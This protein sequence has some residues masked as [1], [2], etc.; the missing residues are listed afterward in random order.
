[1]SETMTGVRVR[2]GFS[3]R[4]R[5]SPAR[6]RGRVAVAVGL[7]E[8]L[9]AAGVGAAG[10]AA[11]GDISGSVAATIG[12]GAAPSAVAVDPGTH[13]AYVT[14]FEDNTVS[15]INGATNTG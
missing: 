3:W 15:V 11:A 1:M 13:T 12:V 7:L 8:M 10:P 5:I 14:N 2:R 9:L 6:V 4:G